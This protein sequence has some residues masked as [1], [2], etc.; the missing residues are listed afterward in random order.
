MATPDEWAQ[1]IEEIA[2]ATYCPPDIEVTEPELTSYALHRRPQPEDVAV[3]VQFNRAVRA[4]RDK[5]T[6]TIKP[7]PPSTTY[8]IPTGRPA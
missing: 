6:R 5:H 1:R 3:D 4:H 8:L 2:Q 7:T